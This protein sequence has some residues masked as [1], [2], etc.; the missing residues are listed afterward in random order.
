MPGRSAAASGRGF[1][2]P[3]LDAIERIGNRLP[4]QSTIFVILAVV[5]LIGS[6]VAASAGLRIEHPVA[7]NPPF[8]SSGRLSREG[9]QWV[10]TSVVKN[11]TGFAPLG[12]V[13]VTMIGVGIAERTGLFAAL[14]KLLVMSVPRQAVTPTI[15]FAGLMSHSAADAG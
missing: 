12:V 5:T 6:W 10:L 4:D 8:V 15:I 13:L 7:G 9:F 2:S 14:L 11:F 3:F 1:L